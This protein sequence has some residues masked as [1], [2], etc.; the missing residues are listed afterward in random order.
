VRWV[1]LDGTT[2]LPALLP[3]P[4][5]VFTSTNLTSLFPGR[6]GGASGTGSG[7]NISV[8]AKLLPSDMPYVLLVTGRDNPP[9]QAPNYVTKLVTLDFVAPDV[10]PPVFQ[11]EYG[12]VAAVVIRV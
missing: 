2:P 7:T 1:V 4:Q 3:T 9:N 5:A 8:T 6:L 10:T 11:S 12:G